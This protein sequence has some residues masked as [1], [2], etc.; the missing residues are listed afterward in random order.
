[1]YI[2]DPHKTIIDFANFIT[3]FDLQGLV[4]IFKEY[5]RSEHKNLALLMDYANQA[6]N[7]TLYKRLGFLLELYEPNESEYI[8]TC[9]H[10]ISKGPSQLSPNTSCDVYIK[11]WHLKIPRSMI[12]P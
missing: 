3:D 2:S 9:L 4:D 6:K 8:E 12:K 10:K 7:R 11:K 5:L 1:M